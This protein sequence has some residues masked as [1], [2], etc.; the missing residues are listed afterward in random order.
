MKLYINTSFDARENLV[1]SQTENTRLS[2]PT[3]FNGDSLLFEILFVDGAGAIDS[4]FN[5]Q[6]I[7]NVKVAVGDLDQQTLVS[8]INGLT[9]HS[10][11]FWQGTLVL[12]TEA[13]ANELSNT[14][15]KTFQFEIQ[16]I[17]KSGEITTIH[18]SEVTIRNQLILNSSTNPV[19][20]SD[21]YILDPSVNLQVGQEIRI[22]TDFR[23]NNRDFVVDEMFSITGISSAGNSVKVEIDGVAYWIG[24]RGTRFEVAVATSTGQSDGTGDTG[25]DSNG[26]GDTGDDSNGTGDTGDTGDDSQQQTDDQNRTTFVAS[27]VGRTIVALKNKPALGLVAGET[28]VITEISND[29]TSFSHSAGR[30]IL[31]VRREDQWNF[32]YSNN[33]Q[34]N[35]NG[36]TTNQAYFV[37]GDDGTNGL[38]YYYPVYLNNTGLTS[39]HTHTIGGVVYYMED[40]DAN[41]AESELPSNNTLPIAPNTSVPIP[42]AFQVGDSTTWYGTTVTILQV[43]QDG[44]Y[45]L[46]GDGNGSANAENIQESALNTDINGNQQSG[47]WTP[48]YSVGQQLTFH[49]TQVTID[50]IKTNYLYDVENTDGFIIVDVHESLLS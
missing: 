40:S 29:G 41:H 22:L 9:Q 16:V 48:L 23:M 31:W 2:V 19:I 7:S 1:V 15:Q 39:S 36:T 33:D 44:T 20:A 14:E 35:D 11:S 8:F 43:N 25:D 46:D 10:S 5:E 38:G 42:P 26:T 13:L 50:S 27:D 4:E 12:H 17:K 34:S 47:T 28:F 45:D 37:Y 3:L 32:V 24:Q 6:S 18:Q 21:P 49:N 30:G